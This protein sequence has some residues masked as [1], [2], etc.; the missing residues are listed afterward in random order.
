MKIVEWRKLTMRK[1][2]ELFG[3]L[4]NHNNKYRL[5]IGWNTI[6]D[7]SMELSI[8]DTEDKGTIFYI[9]AIEENY[10]YSYG[11]CKLADYLSDK[12]GGY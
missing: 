1:F 10:L 2:Y 6:I 12:Y 4:K 11:Y 7:W 8:G 5:K 3:L 9:Q